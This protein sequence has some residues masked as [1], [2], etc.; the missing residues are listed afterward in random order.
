MTRLFL[1]CEWADNIGSELVS[2]ALVSEDDRYRF[3]AELSPLPAHPTSFARHVVYPLLDHGQHARQEA[4]LTRGLR[5]FLASIPVPHVLYDDSVDGALFRY[6]LDGFELDDSNLAEVPAPQLQS[7]LLVDRDAIRREADRY[8]T[9]KPDRASRRH[10]ALAD[11]EA[12]RWA[13][14]QLSG[15][16]PD[17][18]S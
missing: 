17:G 2:L 15:G 10:H 8:F 18:D 5:M 12:L 7:T 16:R 9:A 3:Y 13:F 11:A 1:D 14:L 4:E 6:A